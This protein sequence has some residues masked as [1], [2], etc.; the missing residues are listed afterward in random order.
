MSSPLRTRLLHTATLYL[1]AHRNLDADL[2]AKIY[3][4]N[5]THSNYP[6]PITPIFPSVSNAAYLSGVKDLF[7]MW[8]S[9]TITEFAPAIVDEEARKVVLFVSGKGEA[10]VGTYVNEYVVVLKCDDEVSCTQT[11][12][13]GGL[14]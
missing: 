6:A 5:A 8:H 13:I 4:E 1:D 12:C 11:D 10:D 14:S 3:S 7:A 9:F 2:L